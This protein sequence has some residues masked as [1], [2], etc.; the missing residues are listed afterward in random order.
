MTLK[1][2]SA[3]AAS[4][5]ISPN[6]SLACAVLTPPNQPVN[7][8]TQNQRSK[9]YVRVAGRDSDHQFREAALRGDIDGHTECF[10][11]PC[12]HR[13]PQI[14]VRCQGERGV[15]AVRFNGPRRVLRG[16]EGRRQERARAPQ[17]AN[18]ER[19]VP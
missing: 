11:V 3:P 18:A 2:D 8:V 17:M 10:S 9:S 12:P 4:R 6:A 19:P 14:V 15:P 16:D 7:D 1:S 5:C 13:F